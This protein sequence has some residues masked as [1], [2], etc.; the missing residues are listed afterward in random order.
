MCG[1]LGL[2]RPTG[3]LPDNADFKKALGRL[4]RRGPDDEGVWNDHQ[5]RLGHKRL[6]VVDLSPAGHQ[7]MLS[8]DGRYVIVFNGE[9][10]NHRELREQL[11]APPG[12]WR[13]TSDTE[14]LIEAFRAWGTESL[15]RLSGMFAFAIWDRHEHSLFVAR[16]RMG[17]KPLYYSCERGVVGF[18][19]RPAALN[20]AI[21]G[22][23]DIDP[24]ALR[25]YLELGYVPAP[26]S[27]YRNI[28][29]L[30]PGHY[31]T[32]TQKDLLD[33]REPKIVRYWDFRHIAPDP[34]LR[35]RPEQ[36]LVAEL[37]EIVRRV[38]KERLLS[39]VP[40]GAFLSGGADSALVVAAMKAAGVANP[41]AFTISFN[42]AAFDEGP[43]A[44][45][46]A[47]H[48]GVQHVVERVSV[49]NLLGL[50]PMF[51]EEFDEPLA[52]SSA[53]PT[54]AVSRLARRHVTVAL[55]GD[56][57]DELFGGY[58]HYGL[59]QRLAPTLGWSPPMKRRA[60]AV[61][62]RLP[63]H[64]LKQLAGA[65]DFD[66]PIG[67]FQYLRNYGKDFPSLVDPDVLGSTGNAESWLA[68]TAS[69][70]ALDLEPAE[71]GMRLDA[72]LLLPDGYLQKVDV[73][74][75]AFS[76][77]AR[78]PFTDY[79][80]VEWAMRLPLDFK[81]RRH[82]TKHLLKQVLCQYLP[83]EL[84]YRPKMGFSVPL[85]QWLRGSLREWAW[86]LINDATL[87]ARVPLVKSRIDELY[88][89]HLSGRRD[90]HPLLWATLVLL[91]FVAKNDCRHGVPEIT[92]HRAA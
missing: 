57:S 15:Q 33:Q 26:L 27:F 9:I 36:E 35:K 14:T 39:D 25:V 85:A 48:L 67:L 2:F 46:I 12:G 73:A 49:D 6:A 91:C 70:F 88:K 13:S 89:M 77:E 18:A 21:G 16:D 65:L 7:P 79:R 63:S 84:V 81:L 30:R 40:L 76:L 11:S 87:M 41:Q 59:A 90:A 4:G 28:R 68:Q 29:K 10:Y 83:R 42:E 34:S 86:D 43:A 74:S 62:A 45:R 17:V 44:A 69:S 71:T 60:R 58:P 64:K 23:C 1:I 22:F 8:A 32:L 5:I 51:L 20:E 56:G 3:L 19:S 37:D 53:F 66:T 92:Q 55:T 82:R 61:L 52:D 47:Q 31:L 54:L 24:E 80:L 50:M 75:M 72:A 78:C 38:V